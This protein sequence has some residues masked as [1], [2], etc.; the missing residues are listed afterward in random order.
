MNLK[1]IK[2][3]ALIEMKNTYAPNG[4]SFVFSMKFVIVHVILR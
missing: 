1:Y 4:K 3:V 2:G